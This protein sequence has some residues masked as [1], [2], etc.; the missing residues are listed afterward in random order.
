VSLVLYTGE[1]LWNGSGVRHL[2]LISLVLLFCCL[3]AHAQET[4]KRMNEILHPDKN[5]TSFYQNKSFFGGKSYQASN[6]ACVKEFQFNETF[7]MKSYSTNSYA[8]SPFWAGNTKFGT[9]SAN[10]K[11]RFEIPNITKSVDTKTEATKTS[12]Y[13]DKTFASRDYETSQFR[14]VGKS[15][16]ALDQQSAGKKPMTV[17]QVREMLNKNN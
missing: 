17:D 14:G 2:L 9:S 1:L 11:G 12:P 10:T 6:S 15:Q 5:S 7:S 3:A 16:K 8:S 4:E 13:S